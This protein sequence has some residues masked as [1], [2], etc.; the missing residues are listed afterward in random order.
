MEENRPLVVLDASVI[1]KWFLKENEP[2]RQEALQLA[3]NFEE[4]EFD[5]L[6]P[7]H[8]FVELLNT[9]SRKIPEW[10]LRH[11]SDLR[12]MQLRE[13]F[14]SLDIAIIA[15]E[16]TQKYKKISFYDAF[17]HA[18][19][20]AKHAL[21]ITADEKYYQMVKKER[22]I[23]LLKD[24]ESNFDETMQSYKRKKALKG[25]ENL[26]K[27]NKVYLSTEEILKARDEGRK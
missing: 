19:A 4:K 3:Q 26:R 5:I 25:I 6:V 9:F 2:N 21:F 1:V 22:N 17:Y 10:A 16:L 13:V 18:I 7:T 23:L 15:I 24:C 12:T 11:L 20:L 8:C 27:K 14:L